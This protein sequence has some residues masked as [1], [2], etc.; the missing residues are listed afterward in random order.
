MKPAGRR[1][2]GVTLVELMIG[3]A[4]LGILAL[5][6]APVYQ[7]SQRAFTSLEARTSL[8]SQG[9][10][11]VN[12]VGH[13][14]SECK[15]M[16]ENNAND[17]AFLARVQ[18]GTAPAVMAGSVLPVSE[19][20][21]SISP[22]SAAFVAAS[23]GNQLFFASVLAAGDFNVLDSS[24]NTKTVRIDEYWFNRYYIA[25]D[26]A[27][28]S[29][30]GNT[31]RVL[32]EWHSRTYADYNQIMAISDTTKRN[33]TVTALVNAGI[34]YAWDPSTTTVTAAFYT[35]AVGGAVAT[36]SGHT[37]LMG[38]SGTCRD[39]LKLTTGLTVGGFRYGVSPNTGG[40]FSTAYLVPQFAVAS[41]NFPSGFEV[42]DIGPNSARQIFIRLVLVAEGPF[43][44]PI[45]S[46]QVLLTD[47]RDL[48]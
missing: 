9:Q 6:M 23:V 48:W 34:A 38:N 29:V 35:L 5:A 39:M 24:A 46:E 42:V 3:A 18:L 30:G 31:R 11:A 22:S 10:D 36:Q 8:K 14:L 45:G 28:K 7:A 43:P 4:L 21:G 25:F 19:E 12:K 40:G 13:R 2:R 44:G 37:I 20:T 41:V 33:N 26:T 32:W 47:T 15:R 1:N 16:F 27:S 17:N